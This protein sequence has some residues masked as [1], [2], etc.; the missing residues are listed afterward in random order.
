MSARISVF[1]QSFD[2]KLETTLE[3]W[4]LFYEGGIRELKIVVAGKL[5]PFPWDSNRLCGH[6]LGLGWKLKSN[7]QVVYGRIPRIVLV[8]EVTLLKHRR[9]MRCDVSF[10]FP[11]SKTAE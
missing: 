7:M 9:V 2:K 11:F 4:S 3:L 1:L 8:E 6:L 5:R 10:S